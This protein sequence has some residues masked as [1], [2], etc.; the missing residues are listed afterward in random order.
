MNMLGALSGVLFQI[1]DEA[2]LLEALLKLII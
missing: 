2:I 1:C